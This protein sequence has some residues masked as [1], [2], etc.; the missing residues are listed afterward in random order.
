M[1]C[2]YLKAQ[3]NKEGRVHLKPK[4]KQHNL[5]IWKEQ[6]A[7]GRGWNWGDVLSQWHF[8]L[9][10]LQY[11]KNTFKKLFVFFLLNKM[12][13]ILNTTYEMQLCSQQRCLFTFLLLLWKKCQY[14]II[15]HL[16]SMMNQLATCHN[17]NTIWCT[18]RAKMIHNKSPSTF[19][20]GIKSKT[21]AVFGNFIWA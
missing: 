16:S 6:E 4:N 11:I 21:K 8:R 7:S 1:S 18:S 12:N 13:P 20:T 17:S 19:S 14:M 3:I 9:T 2:G 10:D 5:K 15:P